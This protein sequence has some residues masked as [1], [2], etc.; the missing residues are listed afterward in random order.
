MSKNKTCLILSND[1]F[2]KRQLESIYNFDESHKYFDIIYINQI[3]LGN[4]DYK[5]SWLTELV[6]NL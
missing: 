2:S 4:K 3:S 6:N 5:I 1:N